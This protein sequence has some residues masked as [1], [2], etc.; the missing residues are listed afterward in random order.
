MNKHTHINVH[1]SAGN[2]RQGI[3]EGVEAINRAHKA[4]FGEGAKSSLGYYVGYHYVVDYL[5]KFKQT[6]LDTDTGV[7]NNA[8]GMNFKAIGICLL[9]NFQNEEP[10]KEHLETLSK[11]I[12]EIANK[13]DIRRENVTMH[14]DHK[15]TACPGENVAKIFDTILDNAYEPEAAEIPDW[16]KE[17]YELSAEA[18]LLTGDPRPQRQITEAEL[19]TIFDRYDKY[20]GVAPANEPVTTEPKKEKP[21]VKE[22]AEQKKVK[23]LVISPRATSEISDALAKVAL[24]FKPYLPLDIKLMHKKLKTEE[25]DWMGYEYEGNSYKRLR[26]YWTVRNIVTRNNHYQMYA[27]ILDADQWESKRS[28]GYADKHR[29]KPMILIKDT[30]KPRRSNKGWAGNDQIAGTLRHEIIHSL[31]Y[32]TGQEDKTHQFDLEEGNID[33]ALSDLNWDKIHEFFNNLK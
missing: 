15:A 23:L 18:G 4:R 32:I 7:H 27:T 8:D 29:Q 10:T 33:K 12:R 26:N 17:G 30:R 6:R 20:K 24:Y 25:K 2:N 11:L 21:E 31:Y 13:Y 1:H 14:R 9:G 3:E 28:M 19:V 22:E 16:A 5:G